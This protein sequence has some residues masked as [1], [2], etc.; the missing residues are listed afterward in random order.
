LTE[1]LSLSEEEKR[2]QV[3]LIGA[4]MEATAHFRWAI[5][6]RSEPF[7]DWATGLLAFLEEALDWDYFLATRPHRLL[8]DLAWKVGWV[9]KGSS[10][11]DALQEILG[12][13]EHLEVEQAMVALPPEEEGKPL[14]V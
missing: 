10:L 4:R 3:F 7:H 9:A 11:M 2:E 1:R 6:R 12:R 8:A 13:L 5:L 14:V